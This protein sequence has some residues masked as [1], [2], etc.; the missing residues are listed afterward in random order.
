MIRFFALRH[1]AN[2]DPWTL[3]PAPSLRAKAVVT[4]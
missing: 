3:E 2:L 1:A 4:D